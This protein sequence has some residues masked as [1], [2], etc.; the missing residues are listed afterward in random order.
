MAQN[1]WVRSE[2]YDY[3]RYEC[4]FLC[5]VRY[6]AD[7]YRFFYGS[8][9]CRHH[10]ICCAGS[11]L[12]R[13]TDCQG[14]GYSGGCGRRT[15]HYSD[16]HS[17]GCEE[18][19]AGN[20][21]RFT[22]CSR[23]YFILR[24]PAPHRTS[25]SEVCTK[26]MDPRS[27]RCAAD[28]PAGKVPSHHWLSGYRH[29]YHHQS[30]LRRSGSHCFSVEDDLYRYHSWL[31][32]QGRWDCPYPVRGCYLWMHLRSTDRFRSI[33]GCCLRY[34]VCLLW[35]NQ[36][37]NQQPVSQ[38]WVVWLRLYAIFPVGHRHRISGIRI[39]RTVSQPENS[40]LQDKTAVY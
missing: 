38:L 1:G 4:R 12:Y 40:V 27:L 37:S 5:I 16:W 31:W 32:L 3:V 7:S 17:Y 24:C 13:S 15:L 33:T 30:N 25:V 19:H 11:M 28:Y 35:C 9:Q 10:A 14:N 34:G 23:Q 39:L 29:E 22:L 36:L 21:S 18:Y 6:P 26:W 2:D 20:Y 8:R